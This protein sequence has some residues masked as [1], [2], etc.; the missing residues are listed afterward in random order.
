MKN[1]KKLLL[2]TLFVFVSTSLFADW[3]E[4][5]ESWTRGEA[6]A[7]K[8]KQLSKYEFPTSASLPSGASGA[9]GSVNDALG[10]AD[11]LGLGGGLGDYIDSA[12]GAMSML[13][14]DM[15]T[16]LLTQTGLQ[17]LAGADSA[18]LGVC[19]EKSWDFTVPELELPDINIYPCIT[20][21][22][23]FDVVVF[24]SSLP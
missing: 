3:K 6:D 13:N 19:Y 22:G 16:K 8:S 24:C 21:G 7:L 17:V 5:A 20:M 10:S 12:Q 23:G 1:N 14:N 18:M 11:S 2:L 15:Y 4:K 9:I